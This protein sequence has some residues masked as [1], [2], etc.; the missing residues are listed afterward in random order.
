MDKENRENNN[1]I[2]AGQN[3]Y[4][5]KLVTRGNIGK[6]ILVK[7][8]FI[9][10]TESIILWLSQSG[11][12]RQMREEIEEL[13]PRISKEVYNELIGDLDKLSNKLNELFTDKSNKEL[14]N[15]FFIISAK[16]GMVKDKLNE[17]GNE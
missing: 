7:P 5:P 12:L 14:K 17:D 4:K 13:S 15:L 2:W 6:E 10:S 1:P 3:V 11:G 8:Y 16:L 9:E